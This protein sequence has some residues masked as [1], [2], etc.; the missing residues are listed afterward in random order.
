MGSKQSRTSFND[1]VGFF[2]HS[3]NEVVRRGTRSAIDWFEG[4]FGMDDAARV[5][6]FRDRGIRF[7]RQARYV[8]AA[9][10]LEDV[11]ERLPNDTDA[12]FHLAFCYL[13][14]DRPADG[15]AL[16]QSLYDGGQ[17]DHKIASILGMAYLQ[18]RDYQRAEDVLRQGVREH[19]DNFNLNFRLGMALDNLARYDEAVESFQAALKLRP[20]EPR[21]YRSLGFILEQTG[22]RE[23]AVQM[24]KKAAQ[25]ESR[26]ETGRRPG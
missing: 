19:P 15:A 22:A 12:T 25:L 26:Q 4:A 18:T 13:K 1:E 17:R 5:R 21:V 2:L 9:G 14:M 7:T 10:M 20:D 8:Q 3:V 24:F 16:L 11:C 23:Q 6:Y